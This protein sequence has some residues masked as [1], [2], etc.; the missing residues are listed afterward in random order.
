[1]HAPKQN[2]APVVSPSGGAENERVPEPASARWAELVPF[3]HGFEEL[4]DHAR[5]LV[6]RVERAVAR[7]RAS[8]SDTD[9]APSTLAIF[10]AEIDDILGGVG[11][12]ADDDSEICAQHERIAA[13]ARCTASPEAKPLAV[14]AERL[15][16]DRVA[17]ELCMLCLGPDLF[18]R[19]GRVYAYLQNDASRTR[20]SV[21][22]ALDVLGVDWPDR[23]AVRAALHA[24]APLVRKCI[25]SVAPDGELVLDPIVLEHLLGRTSHARLGGQ[26]DDLLIATETRA[27]AEHIIEAAHHAPMFVTMTGD[28]G[29]GRHTL[30]AAIAASLELGIITVGSTRPSLPVSIAGCA[31]FASPAARQSAS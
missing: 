4:A 29:S 5:L 28:Q 30:A 23:L 31:T 22:L 14:L 2:I 19:Y 12:P 11:E 26:L 6:M 24:T 8:R 7:F 9:A 1:V 13:R 20:P 21:A 3:D 17:I 15:Q 10:D 25:V 18:P 27:R 16:L